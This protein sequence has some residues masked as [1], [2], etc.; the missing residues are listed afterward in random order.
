MKLAFVVKGGLHPSGR[1][2]VIPGWLT[3][4]A[5]LAERHD[6]HAFVTRHLPEP[7]TYLLRGIT[8]HDLGRPGVTR[9][10]GRWSEWRSLRAALAIGGRFDVLHGFWADPGVLAALAGR[11][12]H[13]PSVVTCDSGEF[14]ALPA[15]EY[16]LQSHA[17]GRSIVR[18]ACGL[19][20][21]VHVT[22]RFMEE[23]A[24]AHGIDPVR[25]PVGI[26][27]ARWPLAVPAEG[28]PWRLLQ[29]ASLNRVKDHGTLL[30]ALARVR[31]PHD[32]HLDLVGEDTLDGQLAREAT[33]L[34]LADVVH[35]HGFVPHDTLPRFYQA[36]HLYVQ[37]SLHE[38]GGAS[39]LEAA[40]SGVPVVGTRAGHVSDWA[41][42]AA[43]AVPPG[44]ADALA[45]VIVQLLDNR[46]RRRALAAAARRFVVS[47]DID[48]TARELTALY[49]DVIAHP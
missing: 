49:T 10:F 20:T 42:D 4:L 37:S 21:R 40:A 6:V 3:L 14:A 31:R 43:G 34:G 11:R 26:D 5:R 39:V 35:F 27:P 19:A 7:S 28:P 44:E 45:D 33:T 25:I 23:R 46:A 24:R 17:R 9:R 13:I 15:I 8:V 48:W 30:R 1:V 41:P 38:A 22:T 2:Q 12:L 16:G 32:A 29:V 36:A 47:H 18:L